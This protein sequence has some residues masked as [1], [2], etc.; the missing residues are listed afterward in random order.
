MSQTEEVNLKE[1]P[2]LIDQKPDSSK[3]IGLLN[4]ELLKQPIPKEIL[5]EHKVKL[6]MNWNLEIDLIDLIFAFSFQFVIFFLF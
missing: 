4:E 2:Y 6:E 1:I 5:K 3:P